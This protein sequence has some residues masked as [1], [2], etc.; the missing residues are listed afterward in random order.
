MKELYVYFQWSDLS[1]FEVTR[2]SC[3]YET[4]RYFPV[5]LLV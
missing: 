5:I 1:E 3:I 4:F 2:F